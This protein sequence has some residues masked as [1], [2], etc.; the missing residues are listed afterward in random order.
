MTLT[1]RALLIGLV[2]LVAALL[3]GLAVTKA[4]AQTPTTTVTA[5]PLNVAC[6]AW[7]DK[8]YPGVWLKVCGPPAQT[9]PAN[10]SAGELQLFGERYN[11]ATGKSEWYFTAIGQIVYPS[12]RE[13][14]VYSTDTLPQSVTDVLSDPGASAAQK[15]AAYAE[16]FASP[17]GHGVTTMWISNEYHTAAFGASSPGN[18]ECQ[19]TPNNQLKVERDWGVITEDR[20]GLSVIARGYKTTPNG[21]VLTGTISN[22]RVE[23]GNNANWKADDLVSVHAQLETRPTTYGTLGGTAYASSVYTEGAPIVNLVDAISKIVELEARIA[24]LERPQ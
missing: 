19:A 1:N 3:I 23:N 16:F 18:E 15:N 21:A 20:R 8:M 14:T 5:G 13:C 11:P 12:G 10:T 17:D 4:T 6:P 2:L 9:S 22:A 24:A 7:M